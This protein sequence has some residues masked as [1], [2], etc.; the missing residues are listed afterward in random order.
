MKMMLETLAGWLAAVGILFAAIGAAR[1]E[2]VAA[3]HPPIERLERVRP[4]A[5]EQSRQA[6]VVH[7]GFQVELVAAEPLVRSPIAIDFDE[8]GRMYVV[9]YPEY[10]D[11]AAT[12]PARSWSHPP[13]GGPRRRRPLRALDLLCRKHPL[14]Q[15]RVVLRWRRVRRRGARFALSE[16]H[17]RRRQGRRARCGF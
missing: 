17:R 6:I 16:G 13:A 3:Q 11:Y 12:R 4:L 7:P 2:E 10:N 15:W 9:E 1:A 5:P 8:D 14:R